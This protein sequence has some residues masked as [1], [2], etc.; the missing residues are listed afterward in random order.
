MDKSHLAPDKRKKARGNLDLEEAD[1]APENTDKK[2]TN[3][4][5][6]KGGAMAADPF[7]GGEARSP[8]IY[9][10]LGKAAGVE[11]DPE[12]ARHEREKVAKTLSSSEKREIRRSFY[13]RALKNPVLARGARESSLLDGILK[14]F[15]VSIGESE[16]VLVEQALAAHVDRMAL[17]RSLARKTV[18]V[19]K[20]I[21]ALDSRFG[22]VEK[23]VAGRQTPFNLAG[24][25]YLAKASAE[26]VTPDE[27]KARLR[28]AIMKGSLPDTAMVRY[29]MSGALPDNVQKA[30]GL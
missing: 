27:I 30:I 29:E 23:A 9:E 19:G 2:G 4:K 14:S 11:K 6:G 5:M 20:G 3:L 26:G 24:L 15:S 13:E 18:E 21:P 7:D 16:I 8:S 25:G 10:R 1:D 22:A 28:D 12:V 17:A